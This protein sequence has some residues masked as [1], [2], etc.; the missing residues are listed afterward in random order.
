MLC[1]VASHLNSKND[2][3]NGESTTS[4]LCLRRVN[5]VSHQIF[6]ENVWKLCKNTFGDKCLVILSRFLCTSFFINLKK[7][8]SELRIWSVPKPLE[9]ATRVFILL[10][11]VFFPQDFFCVIENSDSD[12][13]YFYTIW[14]FSQFFVTIFFFFKLLL[15]FL[16]LLSGI[17]YLFEGFRSIDF[18][19]FRYVRL[20]CPQISATV[21]FSFNLLLA[22]FLFCLCLF[23]F[24]RYSFSLTVF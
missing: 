20:L 6:G 7:L 18:L 11:F 8:Y 22:Q 13:L 17:F 16:S 5:L 12:N 15:I 14:L 23:F 21:T 24:Y 3:R 1:P 4:K 10:F 2:S 19:H 9:R